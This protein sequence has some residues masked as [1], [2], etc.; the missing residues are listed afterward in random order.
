MHTALLYNKLSE[1][2][3]PYT[4][5]NG[6]SRQKHNSA[7]FDSYSVQTR[8]LAKITGKNA[9]SIYKKFEFGYNILLLYCAVK[10][11]LLCSGSLEL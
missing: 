4:S 5:I 6:D 7:L 3:S 10:Q 2:G 1:D 11:T 9:V 8:T